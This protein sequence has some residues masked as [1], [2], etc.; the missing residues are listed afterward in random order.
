MTTCHTPPA[1]ACYTGAMVSPDLDTGVIDETRVRALARL[2]RL[3]L[4]DEEI[5]TLAA[6]L[7]KIL[8]HV[9][10]LEE[11]DLTGIDP[12][13]HVAFEEPVLRLDTPGPSLP[14]D[15]ALREAPRVSMEGFAVPAFVDEG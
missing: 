15:L 5:R 12:T 9:Q 11:L 10:L 3:D 2:A 14:V 8:A 6:D 1:L 4:P 13:A 7:G